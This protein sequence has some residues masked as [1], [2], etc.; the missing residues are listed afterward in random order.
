[1]KFIFKGDHLLVAEA[2]RAGVATQLGLALGRF[3][4]DVQS[5]TLRL[6]KATD[7]GGPPHERVEITLGLLPKRVRVEHTDPELAVALERAADKAVRTVTRL[8]ERERADKT[9]GSVTPRVAPRRA[10]RAKPSAKRRPA[11]RS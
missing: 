7:H 4:E 8:L 6:T 2:R 9:S 3:G 11:L 10:V 5:V 1:M